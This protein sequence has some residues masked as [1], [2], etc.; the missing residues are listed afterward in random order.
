MRFLPDEMLPRAA[1]ALLRDAFDHDAMHVAEVGLSG[2]DDVLV[3]AVAR[4]ERRAIVTENV[5]DHA[6]ETDLV[7]VAE[8]LDRWQPTTL[9][10]TPV[11]TGRHDR[12][13]THA[14]SRPSWTSHTMNVGQGPQMRIRVLLIAVIAVVGGGCGDA[15]ETG[16]TGEEYEIINASLTEP[17]VINVQV[18]SCNA[19]QREMVI[20]E[21]AAAVEVTVL[22]EGDSIDDCLDAGLDI[23]LAAPLGG[24]ALID[25][26]TGEPVEVHPSENASI[27]R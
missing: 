4:S 5:S 12:H 18:G 10:R 13:A 15:D 7:L 21:D 6:S 19:V 20:D 1:A 27:D 17:Y 23:E 8:L 26:T 22:V 11:S 14:A 2:A 24:R 3:A 16:A 25:G 9:L